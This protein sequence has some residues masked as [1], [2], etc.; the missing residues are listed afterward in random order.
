MRQ[1][2]SILNA[3]KTLASKLEVSPG[4]NENILPKIIHPLKLDG[5]K[6]YF[7]TG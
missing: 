7:G 5:C 3:L 1:E 4:Y 2:T 6:E